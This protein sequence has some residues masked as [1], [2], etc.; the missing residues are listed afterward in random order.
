MDN[1][2]A[3]A[4]DALTE[5]R[6]LAAKVCAR[7][8]FARV[9]GSLEEGRSGTLGG[10]W[11]SARAL[12]AAAVAS[13]CPGPLFVVT[14]HQADVDRLLTDL[15]LFTDLPAA[16]FP[17]WERDQSERVL[18]DEVYGQRMRV[19]KTL[20]RLLASPDQPPG[21]ADPRVVV[22]SIHGLMQPTPAPD[23]IAEA[24]RTVAVGDATG[25]EQLVEWLTSRGCHRTSAVE[26]PGEF[27]VRGGII[28]V[29]PPD[30]EHPVRIEYFGDEVESIR[31]FDVATQRSAG[32]VQTVDL[33]LLEPSASDR[34]HMTVYAPP[35][36][37]FLLI[38]PTDLAEEGRFYHERSDDTRSL[39]SVR[40]SL[41]E[42]YKYPSVTAA[43]VPAGSLEETGHL[44]FES[45]E[46]LSGDIQRVRDELATVAEGQ[47]VFIVCPTDAETQRLTELFADTPLLREDRLRLVVGDLAEGFRVV[48]ERAIV[49]SSAELFNRHD[50]ARGAIRQAAGRAIDTFLELREGDLIVHVTHGIGRYRGIKLLEKEG[51]KE[52]H[53]ELEYHGG[54]RIFV[55]STKIEL[56]QKYVGGKSLKVPLARI[57][58]KAWVR[59]KQAAEKA[60]T[61]LAADMLELQARRDARPGMAFPEDTPWQVEFDAAF[62]Y[63]ET[64]DQLRSIEEIKA[65][66]TQP[67]PMDRL[68]CG[69]VGFGKTELAIRAAFK[70]VDA[71]YQVAVLA[72][73]T[74]LAEQHR[75]T[76]S[77]RMA[78]FPFEIACLSRFC[79]AKEQRQILEKAREGGVDIVIGTHRLA[80]GDVDFANLGLLIIDEEQRFGVAV[81]ERL[82]AMRS[83][84]DVLTMTATPIPR[85]LHMALL[86]ARSISNLETP[87][88]NRLAVE[89]RVTRF[90][91]E[92]VRHAMLRELNRGGQAYFVH[93]RVH[94]I[95]AV[96]DRLNEIVP[97][98]RIGI[99]HGQMPEG[100]L[101]EVMVK[102][103]AHEYDI[104]LA[105]T[106]IESGLDIPNANT[107]FVDDADRYGLADLHQLRGRV[108]R[109][110]RRGYCYLLIQ[111]DRQLPTQAARRL[112]AVEEFS[113]LGAGFA[114]SM[115]DL[116]IRG[117]GN[118]LG[119][120]QSGH[121]A[122]V[123]YEMYCQMLEKAVRQLRK[124]PPKES[125]D[126]TI[127]LPVHAY[128]PGNYVPD[129][130]S[131]IDLY[132]RLARASTLAE[133]ED[134]SGELNDRFGTLPP[135]AERFLELARLRVC[136]HQWGVQTVRRED[137]YLVF[138]YT[139]RGKI[140]ELVDRSGGR[141]RIADGQSAYLP[142][143][144]ARVG[145]EDL[146]GEVKTLLRPQRSAA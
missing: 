44:G 61:D 10:V 134:F 107:M 85:T 116:E 41:A 25:E 97:E 42:V 102:F 22:T 137:N 39:H 144:S 45:V 34:A 52:E 30:E 120:Q 123:G 12:V 13:R 17:A 146:L 104:L 40:T 37:W 124:L 57:G 98:A 86:G 95:K 8:D 105:T 59:Q 23:A 69:D 66:M 47:M 3:V 20:S 77:E 54:T 99:G 64:P 2:P 113:Q 91:E 117:A 80:S 90:N 14:P 15:A 49:L 21:A 56:V 108:G 28:D 67:R 143:D 125:V 11:G 106:I 101:E 1:P 71:G 131:K 96:A 79:T 50:T 141:L 29:F 81:K 6:R 92:M 46:R 58:G 94:D 68:L 16:A 136:A 24:T 138:A 76:F 145:V 78:E 32:A 27:A 26:L 7:D 31:H 89:T 4:V 93:N 48:A 62:P 33:T 74:V 75:R 36:S 128:L 140:R 84:V 133:V 51:R 19:L 53:L 129:M 43:G 5:L 126:V 119:T 122:T 142:L 118:L 18:H 70:A 112:R 100:E 72:P 88:S 135:P 55:P 109:A 82:K 83:A 9:V 65:D 111:E 114:L 132:R 38:E 87:P 73:T 35:E 110:N 121:I 60:V 139:H 103:V 130:R 127:D 115:R 63:E